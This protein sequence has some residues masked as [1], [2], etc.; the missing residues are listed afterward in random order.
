MPANSEG[1]LNQT[2]FNFTYN[3]SGNI[4][5]PDE[6]Y[7][8]VTLFDESFKIT[9]YKQGYWES[10][11]MKSNVLFKSNFTPNSNKATSS[12]SSS[13]KVS[14]D[15]TKRSDYLKSFCWG[16]IFWIFNKNSKFE[17]LYFL[18]F[19]GISIIFWHLSNNICNT[20][21]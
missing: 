19:S 18:L 10:S 17:Y 13:N 20:H 4:T 15:L 16:I 5:F 2:K 6:V 7:V 12:N 9:L 3:M 8:S 14:L 21:K 11:S 1:V